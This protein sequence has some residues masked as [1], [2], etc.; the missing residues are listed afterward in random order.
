MR[1]VCI[2]EGHGE[3]E[4]LP[5]LLRRLRDRVSPSLPLEIPKPIRVSK[6]SLLIDVEF[7]RYLE[8][9]ARQLVDPGDAVLVLMDADDDA[10]CQLG[11]KLLQVCESVRPDRSFSVVIATKEYEAWFLAAAVSL[12]GRRGL[13]ADMEPPEDPEAIRDAK[14][15]LTRHNVGGRS[16]KETLDQPALTAVFDMDAA[17]TTTSFDKLFRDF[18]RLI[19]DAGSELVGLQ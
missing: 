7:T 13:A 4:A 8:L 14:G 6:S 18:Q 2:V 5:I 17:L 19:K 3:V 12:R 15:W 11:P 1:I 9:A 10:A 16:Y